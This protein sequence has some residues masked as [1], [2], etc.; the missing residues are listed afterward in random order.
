[1]IEDTNQDI[2]EDISKGVNP[3]V[4]TYGNEDRSKGVNPDVS[5]DNGINMDRYI[6][7]GYEFIPSKHTWVGAKIGLFSL[8]LCKKESC[9]YGDIDFIKVEP[10]KDK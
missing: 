7:T 10:M 1:M 4:S 2:N 5:M 6:E 3:N 8:P 9:G